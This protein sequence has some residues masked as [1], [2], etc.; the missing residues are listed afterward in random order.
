MKSIVYIGMD[1]HKNS[2]SLCALHK[3]TGEILG[4][5]RIASDI[6]LVEKF[7]S[8]IKKKVDEEVEIKTGYEAGC[9]GYSLYHQLTKRNI[10]CDILAPTTMAKSAKNKVVK[11]DRMDAKNIAEN[12]SNGTYKKVYVPCDEDVEVKEY[13]R[14]L[15]DFKKQQKK[16]KQNINAF[17][18]RHDLR[19]EG[20]SRWISTHIKWLKK[21]EVSEMYREI[22]DEYIAEF[23]SLQ[24]KIERVS[25]RIDELSHKETYEKK[26]GEVRCLK[27]IDTTAAM[28]MHVEISDFDRFPNAKAFA[29]YVGLTPGDN[30]SGDKNNHTSI[31]KQ[32]N[33]TVRTTLVECAQALVKGTPGVKGKRVT[34]RQKGQDVKVIEYADRAVVRLQKKYQKMIFRGVPRNKVITAIAR[35]LACFVWGIET[36]HIN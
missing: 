21:V 31:T 3:E 15:D 4:E 17:T 22:L 23:E 18:L 7:I 32:G 25:Y 35:E 12:L 1:V 8:N 27:G 33:S 28:T 9:L 5:S 24:E 13:I 34:T 30:S 19:Y 14:M 11:N 10:D 29:T 26:I 2:Y 16:I 6:K 20:K 36:G